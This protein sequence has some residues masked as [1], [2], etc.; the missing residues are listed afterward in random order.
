MVVRSLWARFGRWSSTASSG[1]LLRDEENE[2]LNRLYDELASFAQTIKDIASSSTAAEPLVPT[3]R[4]E[5]VVPPHSPLFVCLSTHPCGLD[6]CAATHR[7]SRFVPT[8][9]HF[10]QLAGFYARRVHV[11][12]AFSILGRIENDA[13]FQIGRPARRTG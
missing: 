7:D 9:Y 6:F 1:K 13:Q 2:D 3:A 4:R 8:G 10:L 12:Q 5:Y 11:D